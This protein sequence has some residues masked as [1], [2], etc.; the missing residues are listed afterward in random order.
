MNILYLNWNLYV[1]VFLVSSWSHPREDWKAFAWQVLVYYLIFTKQKQKK[2]TRQVPSYWVRMSWKP[3]GAQFALLCFNWRWGYPFIN[4]K[5]VF[6][7]DIC[8]NECEAER[9]AKQRPLLGL[10]LVSW[11]N[12]KTLPLKT[13]LMIFNH[14][15]YVV[16]ENLLGV[17]WL[18]G[19]VC[20]RFLLFVLKLRSCFGGFFGG[21]AGVRE[22][23]EYGLQKFSL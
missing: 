16:W 6:P 1:S 22:R 21:G 23:V 4:N 2:K 20:E 19:F 13:P 10:S 18:M 12:D 14:I 3:L 7:Q 9:D 11:S 17:G 8:W 5:A 15:T